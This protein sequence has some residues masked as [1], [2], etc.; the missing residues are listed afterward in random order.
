MKH[1]LQGANVSR[2]DVIASTEYITL[3]LEILDTCILRLDPETGR[4]RTVMDTIC[5]NAANAGIV[6]GSERHRLDTINPR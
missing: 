3:S 5:D 2:A 1:D 4:A 6:L